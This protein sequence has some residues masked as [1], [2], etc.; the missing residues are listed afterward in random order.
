MSG[1]LCLILT[2]PAQR[3]DTIPTGVCKKRKE[4]KTTAYAG[5]SGWRMRMF[6]LLAAVVVA[7]VG[8]SMVGQRSAS[9]HDHLIPRTV[10]VKREGDVFTAPSRSPSIAYWRPVYSKM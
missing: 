10:L 6:V 3:L 8:V 7:F 1:V 2:N 9:A 5:A 4:M